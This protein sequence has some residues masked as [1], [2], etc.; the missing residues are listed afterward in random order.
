[1]DDASLIHLLH[2]ELLKSFFS[3]LLWQRDIWRR[4]AVRSAWFFRERRQQTG[5]RSSFDEARWDLEPHSWSVSWAAARHITVCCPN[6]QG[7]SQRAEPSRAGTNRPPLTLLK[8]RLSIF[9]SEQKLFQSATNKV[10]PHVVVGAVV[11]TSAV[12]TSA[13]RRWNLCEFLKAGCQRS[14]LEPG[15]FFNCRDRNWPF[16]QTPT[17]SHCP[18]ELSNCNQLQAG[19]PLEYSTWCCRRMHVMQESHWHSAGRQRHFR[20]FK[21]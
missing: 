4:V 10:V 12:R 11:V 9:N 5:S 1:M 21:K 15:L 6:K 16:A 19:R 13:A 8:Y 20:E 2:S 17:N 14:L 7:Q 18:A 3:C